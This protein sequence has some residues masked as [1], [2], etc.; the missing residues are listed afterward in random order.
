M[1]GLECTHIE[2]V[3]N[4]LKCSEYIGEILWDYE[5][6]FPQHLYLILRKYSSVNVNLE[7]RCF[8]NEGVISASQRYP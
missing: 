5:H 8:V 6:L 7:F 3:L 2:D 1:S 4:V